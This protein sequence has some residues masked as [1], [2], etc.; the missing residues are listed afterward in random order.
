LTFQQ[1]ERSVIVHALKAAS[2]RIAGKGGAAERLGLKRTTLQNKMVK[3]GITREC[4][5]LND[6]PSGFQSELATP[7]ER[8]GFILPSGGVSFSEI[9]KEVFRQ[10]LKRNRWNQSRAARYLGVTRDTLNYRIRKHG[11]NRGKSGRLALNGVENAP[12]AVVVQ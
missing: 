2:G 4:A 9:E 5:R 6:L 10:A 8:I 3:L 11:L 1:A 12:R 7:L